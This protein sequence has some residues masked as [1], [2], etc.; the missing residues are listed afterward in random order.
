LAPDSPALAVLA[1]GASILSWLAGIVLVRH[2]LVEELDLARR[3]L[4]AAF[5]H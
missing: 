4:A 3:K 5:S 1:G 2:P